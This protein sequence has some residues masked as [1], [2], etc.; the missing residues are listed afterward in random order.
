MVKIEFLS[1]TIENFGP[2]IGCHNIQ[3]SIDPDKNITLIKGLQVGTGKTTLNYFLKY[4]LFPIENIKSVEEYIPRAI[5]KSTSFKMGGN[6]IFNLYDRSFSLKGEYTI[7]KYYPVEDN[8]L[9]NE[10]Y[11]VIKDGIELTSEEIES[12]NLNQTIF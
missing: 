10:E 6:L 12:E 11:K 8:G 2:Y 9:M 7:S 5:D 3:F 4:L 1:L